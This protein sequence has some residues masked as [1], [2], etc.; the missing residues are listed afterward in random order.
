MREAAGP[1]GRVAPVRNAQY[2]AATGTLKDA[3]E[4]L[5]RD[6]IHH[7]LIRT[8]WNKSQLAKELGISRSNLIMKVERVRPRQENG[9]AAV[10]ERAPLI[11]AVVAF[12]V[13][14]VG[15]YLAGMR[16]ASQTVYYFV[17]LFDPVLLTNRLL[18]S[19]WYQHGQPP[20]F[21]LLTGLA[22]GA[23]FNPATGAG[24]SGRSSSWRG[25]SR[26]W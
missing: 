6:L 23:G 7:G 26:C 9:L 14:R 19:L 22:F 21:N 3:V 13:S 12:V 24:C 17:Q 2:D 18:E 25:W 4:A 15:Y 11:A 1:A 5:E 16:F 8:H 20:L 10:R